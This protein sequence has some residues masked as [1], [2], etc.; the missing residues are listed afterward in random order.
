MQYKNIAE[1]KEQI[2]RSNVAIIHQSKRFFDTEFLNKNG[3]TLP[4][5]SLTNL[6]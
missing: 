2:S 3:L 1:K 5:Q 6:T 4:L